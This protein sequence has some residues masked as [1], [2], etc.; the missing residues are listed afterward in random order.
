MREKTADLTRLAL[1]LIVVAALALAWR[2]D[3]LRSVLDDAYWQV[4]LKAVRSLGKL[5]A[6][7]AAMEIAPLMDVP[8]P[9]LRK[10][11]AAALGELAVR[12]TA[13][14]LEKYA[15]DTDPDVRKN[16]R[17]ALEKLAA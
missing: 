16:V 11:C 8:V 6:T 14:F 7:E 15:D 9:N 17:W 2:S 1:P 10:E 4:R 3:A 13:P 12:E 5:G